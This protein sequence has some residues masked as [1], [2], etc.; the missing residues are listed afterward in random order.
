M[1]WWKANREKFTGEVNENDSVEANKPKSTDEI[2][3]DN[4]QNKQLSISNVLQY[5]DDIKEFANVNRGN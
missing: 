2:E 4:H 5:L 3:I 1:G